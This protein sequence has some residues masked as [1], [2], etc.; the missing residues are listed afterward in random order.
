MLLLVG[1]SMAQIGAHDYPES[2]TEPAFDSYH[3]VEIEDPYRWLEDPDDA[4]TQDWVKRQELFTHSLLDTLPQVEWLVGRFEE[5]WRYDSR[6]A[7]RRVLDGD[8]IYYQIQNADDEKWKVV[9]KEDEDSDPTVLI[10]PNEWDELKQLQGVS[11]SRTGRYVAYGVAEGGNED[12]RIQILDIAAGEVLPDTLNGWDQTVN[13]WLPDDTGFY[14]S[15]NPMPGE[16][17]PGEEYYWGRI[18]LHRLGTPASEDVLV[19][20]DDEVK[21]RWHWAEVSE[22]GD[23]VIFNKGTY[24]AQEL[25]LGEAGKLSDLEPIVTGYDGE[26]GALAVD[27]KILIQT[28]VD[29]PRGM[30]YITSARKPGKKH[31]KV[32]VPEHKTD[33]LNGIEAIGGHLY[34]NYSHDA[35]SRIAVY[36][37]RGKHLKD[38]ELPMLGTAS[39]SGNW[40]QQ[41]V[42]VAFSSFTWPQTYFYYDVRDNS[43][44]E[45]YRAPV[46]VNVDQYTAQQ[47]WYISKDGTRVS[48]FLVHRKDLE[49]NGEN[50]VYLTGYGGFD[51]SMRPRFSSTNLT[52]V[53]LGGVYALPN[54]RG[55]G[56]YGDDWHK[57]GMLGNKQNVF[58]DFIAA[59]EYLIDEGYT[60][61]DRLAIS[62]GSNGGLLTGAAVVQRPELFAAVEIAVPLLDMLR[63]HTNR[64]A[65]VWAEEYGSSDDPEQFD[66]LQAYSPYH[67]VVEGA[68]YP[69]TL[70]WASTNDA[71]VD[72]YHA[73]KMTARMQALGEGGPV[74]Y[75]ERSGSG[76]HGG[77]TESV[78]MRQTAETRAFLMHFVGMQAP[79][80]GDGE[81]A[82]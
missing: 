68:N 73:R 61:R 4:T 28:T 19:M 2:K 25:Y 53:E 16:V 50:P 78:R 3:G 31:W 7:P 51:V 13:D 65:N 15:S 58:D 67:N 76:H 41:Q 77:T 66:Y 79:E 70:I 60:S 55:G 21:E 80:S 63:Y 56:E 29:A 72:A 1:V 38:I 34:L 11:F 52:W 82:E 81:T 59:A 36:T 10:D 40:D 20:K 54:L 32:L 30:I 18:W 37:L 23:Y 44:D 57:A 47:V 69:P 75:L 39:V 64:Y 43:L 8:R 9:T 42:V 22:N 6:T 74:M 71:R 26:Y 17:P 33:I 35:S 24:Y 12:P 49:L 14:Y 5:L 48:M 27:D 46:K 62:G 45:F